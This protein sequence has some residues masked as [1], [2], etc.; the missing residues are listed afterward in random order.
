MKKLAILGILLVGLQLS[1]YAQ[2]SRYTFDGDMNMKMS[3]RYWQLNNTKLETEKVGGL[4]FRFY[5]LGKSSY[6]G[7]PW[8]YSGR[9]ATIPETFSWAVFDILFRQEFK[10]SSYQPNVT[11][12]GDFLLGWHNFAYAVYRTDDLQVAVGVNGH[13]YFFAHQ[14]ENRS[15]TAD[16]AG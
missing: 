13:D 4:A 5:D 9:W 10:W 1:S 8:Q 6:T 11:V 14:P 12:I 16:P 15:E 7:S 2:L 3:L